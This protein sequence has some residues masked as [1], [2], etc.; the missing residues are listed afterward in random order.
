M[1]SEFL[2]M[3]ILIAFVFAG[4][5]FAVYSGLMRLLFHKRLRE[6]EFALTRYPNYADIRAQIAALHYRY[7]YPEEARRWYYDALR[8]YRYYH[9]ARLKLGLLCLELKH[10]EEALHHFRTIRREA[11]DDETLIRLIESLM[12][13]KGLYDAYLVDEDGRDDEYWRKNLAAVGS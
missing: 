3:A 5:I 8:I 10:E 7:G 4:A 12:R 1:K 13:E 9:Y 6:L 2:P 11:T